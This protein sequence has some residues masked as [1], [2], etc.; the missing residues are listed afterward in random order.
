[1]NIKAEAKYPDPTLL[2]G[3]LPGKE[4]ETKCKAHEAEL[5]ANELFQVHWDKPGI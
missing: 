3:Q 2:I 4:R 1:M 5:Q